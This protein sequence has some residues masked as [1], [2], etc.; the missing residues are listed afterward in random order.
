MRFILKDWLNTYKKVHALGKKLHDSNPTY[1][2][3]GN[4]IAPKYA[5][6]KS[7][8]MDLQSDITSLIKRSNKYMDQ[9]G[10]RMPKPLWYYDRKNPETHA[11]SEQF[12]YGHLITK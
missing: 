9:C 1:D 8:Q 12:I 5:L 10:L 11:S 7:V 2:S 6:S 3:I 4:Y